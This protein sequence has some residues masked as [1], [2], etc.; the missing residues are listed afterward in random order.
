MGNMTEDDWKRVKYF[1]S[2]EG[3]GDPFRMDRELI[4]LM[5]TLRGLFHHPFVIHCGYQRRPEKPKSQHNFGRA[6]DFH[7]EGISFR[8]AVDLMLAFIGPPPRGLGAA[9]NIGLGIY[10]HWNNPGFHLD[11]RGERARWGAVNEN[12]RQIY[13]SFAAAYDKI[14]G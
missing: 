9:D 1:T 4:F 11:T 13:V 7:I 8:D 5:D 3:W 6:A 10:P 14:G 12:G 2:N